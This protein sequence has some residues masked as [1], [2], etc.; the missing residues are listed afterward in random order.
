MSMDEELDADPRLK[1]T[2]EYRLVPRDPRVEVG[3]PGPIV[4]EIQELDVDADGE[5]CDVNEH[6]AYRTE[7]AAR[8][9]LARLE[10]AE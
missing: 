2:T 4:W 6:S 8:K 9:A 10:E 7:S 1:Y 3:E 5:I